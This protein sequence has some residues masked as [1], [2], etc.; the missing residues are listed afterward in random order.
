MESNFVKYRI[1]VERILMIKPNDQIQS[2]VIFFD[3]ER[4][5]N[6]IIQNSFEKFP[7][8]ILLFEVA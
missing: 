7:H 8:L 5:F 4:V 1:H 3:F 6:Y 2:I